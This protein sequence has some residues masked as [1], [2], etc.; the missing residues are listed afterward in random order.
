MFT[1]LL[2]LVTITF[3]SMMSPGPDMLL[4]VRYSGGKTRIP[5]ITCIAGICVGL[6]VHVAFSILGIATAIAAS[7]TL[8]TAMKFAGAGYLI[9]IGLKSLFAKVD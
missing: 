3:V 7:T 2:I 8:Y 1:T 6:S 4:I 9:Y 5:A